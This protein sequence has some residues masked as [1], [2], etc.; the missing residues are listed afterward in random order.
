M[1]HNLFT[2][3]SVETLHDIWPW[4]KEGLEKLR[5][6]CPKSD[7]LFEDVYTSIRTGQSVLFIVG[8]QEGFTVVQRQV[9][10]CGPVMFVWILQGELAHYTDELIEQYKD[11]ARKMGA[12]KIRYNSPRKAWVK[13]GFEPVDIV[14]EMRV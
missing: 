1:T 13:W 3:V 6:K 10:P 12:R 5:K 9:H 4:V 14:Y 7:W 11:M 2:A 8:Q